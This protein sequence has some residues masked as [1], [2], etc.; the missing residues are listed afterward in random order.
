MTTLTVSSE[1]AAPVEQVFSTFTDIEHVAQ[2]VTG[3]RSIE[4]MTAG[5]FALGTRW[6]EV[7]EV[8]AGR[9]DDAVMEVTSFER[10]RTYTITHHKGPA[11][12]ETVFSFEPAGAGTRVTIAY[13]LEGP[14][15]PPA[16]LS[17][18]G[19][20]I[21]GKVREVLSRDLEDLKRAA[22]R[23]TSQVAR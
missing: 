3:I 8:P 17:P 5:P 12:I 2:D 9:L 16:L 22:E 13:T 19:W 4:V 6:R 20:A 14:G 1:I 11:K 7:R 10:N 23:Q 21:S 15:L 18:L